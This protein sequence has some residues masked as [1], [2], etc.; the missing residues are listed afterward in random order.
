MTGQQMQKKSANLTN[1]FEFEFPKFGNLPGSHIFNNG[2]RAKETNKSSTQARS[3][4]TS[5]MSSPNGLLSRHDSA[6]RS[7]S[8]KSQAQANGIPSQSPSVSNGF[9]TNALQPGAQT[10]GVDD[11]ASLFSPSILKTD[12]PFDQGL[13]SSISQKTQQDS[14]SSDNSFGQPS[15]VF[16]F[17]STPSNTASPSDSSTSQYNAN[18]SCGTSPEPSHNSPGKFKPNEIITTDGTTGSYVCHGNSEGEVA[19]CEKLNMACGNPRNPIPRAKSISN[20]TPASQIP[21]KLNASTVSKGTA[22]VAAKSPAAEINGIDW[23]ANQNGGQFDPMLFGDYRESQDAIVGGGDFTGGFFSDA[24]T[25]PDF[26]SPAVFGH[27]SHQNNLM[28]E[29]EKTQNGVDEEEE[30][31]PGEDPTQML[32]CNKIWYVLCAVEN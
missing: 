31:V 27:E 6:G 5:T 13:A 8:P 25:L 9:P 12:N 23:L 1:G 3:S 26:G 11:L 14:S 2:A 30:M 10:N 32:S 21:T 19:F 24:F 15:R 4:S 17:N 22:A 7:L 29:I 16:R 18:S 28:A 20:G